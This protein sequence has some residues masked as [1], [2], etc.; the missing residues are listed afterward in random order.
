MAHFV[1][2]L[3]IVVIAPYGV[4]RIVRLDVQ[5][6]GMSPGGITFA[7]EGFGGSPSRKF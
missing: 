1:V 5:W 3:V 7:I 2:A 6:Q 4:Q